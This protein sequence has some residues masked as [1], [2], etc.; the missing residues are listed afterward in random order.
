LPAACAPIPAAGRAGGA[1]LELLLNL[2]PAEMVWKEKKK[3]D[4]SSLISLFLCCAVFLFFFL[5]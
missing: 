4:L 2:V 1:G 5:V 3:V